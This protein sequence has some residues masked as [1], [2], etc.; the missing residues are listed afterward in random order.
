MNTIDSTGPVK[1]PT[2][3]YEE[4]PNVSAKA[5]YYSEID[6]KMKLDSHYTGIVTKIDAA[7][8]KIEDYR[9]AILA[10]FSG[11]KGKV[12]ARNDAEVLMKYDQNALL[13][14][15]QVVCN[16]DPVN[17]IAHLESLGLSYRRRT[18][19]TKK[20]I[21]V[22][23]GDISGSFILLVRSPKVKFAVL[24]EYTTTPSVE[25]SWKMAD[26]SQDTHGYI[27]G[28][29]KGTTYYFRARFSLKNSIKTDWTKVFDI[30]CH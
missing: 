28:L 30:V 19:V 1:A 22:R 8:V 14:D 13:A 3:C 21:E 18:P 23:Y 17:A 6:K 9:T 10:A 26:F 5:D 25:N 4:P 20:D 24:W 29:V 27:D 16:A 7:V 12:T 11:T 2:A 15:V